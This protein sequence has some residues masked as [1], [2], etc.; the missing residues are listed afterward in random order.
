MNNVIPFNKSQIVKKCSFCGTEEK[1]AKHMIGS[2]EG[3]RPHY[4]CDKCIVKAKLRLTEEE[5]PKTT[6][7]EK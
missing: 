1:A 6:L 7:I 4:I 5:T 2:A 3:L